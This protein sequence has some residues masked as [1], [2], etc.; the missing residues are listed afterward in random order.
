MKPRLTLICVA[1]LSVSCALVAIVVGHTPSNDLLVEC[2]GQELPSSVII[3]EKRIDGWLSDRGHF[4]MFEHSTNGAE[5]L[6]TS[7]FRPCDAHDT[8][9][10]QKVMEG[11]FS[12]TFVPEESDKVYVGSHA[13]KSIYLLMKAHRTNSFLVYLEM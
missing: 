1:T 5:A 7:K 11:S 3:A 2:L 10:L 9:Y 6:L 8:A 13:G 4:W 12:Y